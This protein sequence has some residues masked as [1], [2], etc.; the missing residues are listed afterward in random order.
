MIT[1]HRPVQVKMI[2]TENSRQVLL[3]E[4]QKQRHRLAQE[5]EQWQFQ[6]KKLLIEARKKSAEAEQLVRERIAREERERQEKMAQLDFQ[7][8]QVESLPEGSE[9]LYTTVESSTVIKPGDRWDA[10]MNGTEIILKDG[11][12]HEIRQGGR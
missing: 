12:I 6:S 3:H 1:I 2:L 4:Y 11:I 10:I 7:I 5:W 9:M 8:K